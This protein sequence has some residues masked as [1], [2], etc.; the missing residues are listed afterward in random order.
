MIKFMLAF[1]FGV[2]LA[3]NGFPFTTHQYWILVTLFALNGVE[4]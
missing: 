3:M 2:Y 4:L 1:V